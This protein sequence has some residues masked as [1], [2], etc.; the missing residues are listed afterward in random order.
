MKKDMNTDL[1]KFVAHHLEGQAVKQRQKRDVIRKK[2]T[3][4]KD[5]ECASLQ[6]FLR[7][8]IVNAFKTQVRA[9]GHTQA[10]VI[11]GFIVSYLKTQGM[12]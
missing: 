9:N 10:G 11:R 7:K 6:V 2:T 1:E 12:K 5:R 3:K 4:F 8:D